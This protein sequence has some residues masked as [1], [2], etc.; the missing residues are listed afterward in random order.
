MLCVLTFYPRVADPQFK[1]RLRR[2]NFWE[3]FHGNF[4]YSTLSVFLPEYYWEEVAERNIFYI[5]FC[6]RWLSW[7]WNYGTLKNSGN[8]HVPLCFKQTSRPM[9]RHWHKENMIKNVSAFVRC[10]C[11]YIVMY[12]NLSIMIFSAW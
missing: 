4:M 5:P 6:S 8:I 11:I 1:S 9:I 10:M 3:T 2:T 12:A 7:S